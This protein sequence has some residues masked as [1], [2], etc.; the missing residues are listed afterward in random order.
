MTATDVAEQYVGASKGESTETC[1]RFLAKACVS[2]YTKK[3]RFKIAT[4]IRGSQ[5]VQKSSLA[6]QSVTGMSHMLLS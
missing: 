4:N 1:A 6:T 3:F 2:T 5:N